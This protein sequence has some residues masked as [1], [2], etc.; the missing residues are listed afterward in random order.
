MRWEQVNPG[1]W[2]FGKGTGSKRS[3]TGVFAFSPSPHTR[4]RRHASIPTTCR[5][6]NK[7]GPD[8]HAERVTWAA[9]LKIVCPLQW[10]ESCEPAICGA[11][12]VATAIRDPY[13]CLLRGAP[14]I[15]QCADE[16][17]IA[18]NCPK[19]HTRPLIAPADIH[20]DE[21]IHQ[22]LFIILWS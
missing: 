22:Y 1:L 13:Q 4:P 3:T 14:D 6:E 17:H 8:T 11:L 5:V 18:K 20:V 10:R 12:F 19:S 15:L 16:L 7:G 9:F 2:R 21:D